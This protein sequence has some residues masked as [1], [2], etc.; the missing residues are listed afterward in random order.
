MAVIIPVLVILAFLGITS[1]AIYYSMKL[2]IQ[3]AINEIEKEGG[4]N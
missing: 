1:L 4:E 3:K 2:G